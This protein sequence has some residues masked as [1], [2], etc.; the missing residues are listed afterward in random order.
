MG[1]FNRSEN[2]EEDGP[3]DRTHGEENDHLVGQ[4]EEVNEE[5]N[6]RERRDILQNIKD[7]EERIGEWAPA[8]EKRDRNA[9][10]E[11][12]N[13]DENEIREKAERAGKVGMISARLR[14]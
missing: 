10:R 5:W 13:D 1:A 2:G 3:D 9:E 6:K 12:E 11:R 8:D 4:A 14:G 7:G